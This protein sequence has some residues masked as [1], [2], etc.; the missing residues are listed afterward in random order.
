[1]SVFFAISPPKASISLTTIPLA[2]P[3]IEGLHGASAM[4]FMLPVIRRVLLLSLADASAA[5]QPACPPPTTIM[6]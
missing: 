2:G 5:S 1:M 3:P 6:S 4:F